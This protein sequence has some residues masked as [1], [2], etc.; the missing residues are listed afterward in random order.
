MDDLTKLLEPLPQPAKSYTELLQAGT[1]EQGGLTQLAFE[2][3]AENPEPS[4]VALRYRLAQ[5]TSS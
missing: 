5:S 1:P 4:T 3:Q 2:E